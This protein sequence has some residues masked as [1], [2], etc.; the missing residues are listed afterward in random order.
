MAKKIILA[1]VVLLGLGVLYLLFW[2]VPIDPVAWQP[3]FNPSYTGPYADNTRL[4]GLELLPLGGPR[5]PEE[6]ILDQQGRIYATTEA[7]WIVRLQPDGSQPENWVNTAG[8]PLGMVFDPQENLIVA[9]AYRGLLRVT[10]DGQISE[11][12]TEADGIPIRYANNVDIAADG[13]IYFSDASTKFDPEEYGGTF[14]ASV[15]DIMEHGGHGRVLVYDPESGKASTLVADLNFPNGVALDPGQRFLLINE[16]SK[17]RV[18]RYWLTGPDAG[19]IEPLLEAMPSFPDNLTTGQDG[20][21]WAALI[22]PRSPLLDELADRPWLRKI[23]WRL[24]PFLRPQA[25]SFG[26]ILAFDEHGKILLD[27]QDPE[28]RYPLNSSVTETEDYL[29]LGS[30]RA[31]AVARLP[32]AAIGL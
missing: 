24:P 6:V 20:R 28:G 31:S 29:Y 7:G 3:P 2:P 4:A 32:K 12:A 27:L 5:G 26:H 17:Y 1:V 18:L 23:V 8:R 14:Q 16:G 30:L 22:A 10:P 15:L 25:Q 11:L 19:R 13:K 21:F 9:D